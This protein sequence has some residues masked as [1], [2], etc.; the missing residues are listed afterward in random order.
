MPE[1]SEEERSLLLD[2]A[3]LNVFNFPAR[4]I[5][6]DFLSDSGTTTMTL[7][8]WSKLML[9]DESYGSN[10]GYCKLMDRIQNTFGE[11][12][13]NGE[14]VEI[15]ESTFMF[16]DSSKI[17]AFLFHQGRSAEHAIFTALGR[18]GTDMVI[19]SNGHF[20]TTEAN[21]QNNNIKALNLF[22]PE[23]RDKE[24]E[25]HFKGNID[26]DRLHKTLEKNSENIP[27]VYMTIT[28][29]TGGG[30][31]V[32]MENIKDASKLCHKYGIPFFIDACRFAENAWFIKENEDCYAD[33]NIEDIVKEIFSYADAFSISFKKDGLSNMGGGL[34]FDKNGLFVQKNPDVLDELTNHQILTEGHPTYGGMSGRDIMALEEGLKTV[35]QQGYL[36]SRINQVQ[37][38]GERMREEGLPVVTPIGGHAVYLDMNEFFADTDL[39]KEDYGGIAFTA[40]LLE[41]YGI[42]AC[43]L[44]DFAFGSVDEN[45][46]E[47]FPENNFVRFA[48]PRNRLEEQDLE[49]VTACVKSLY[50][51]RHS[52]PAVRATFGK[53]ATLRHFKARFEYAK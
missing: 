52:I 36:D 40:L 42:R 23:L 49:Y 16:P 24:S 27:A 25:F 29:N 18:T 6:V 26:I 11:Q 7:E 37:K 9:G 34:F 48:V 43:E 22:S 30:Q 38:F 8:Q 50:E 4:A 13:F 2:K 3:G 45:G 51:N 28:N 53:N 35:T 15:G 21:I 1:F 10:D 17:T 32:S 41:K 31:P 19:P 14:K 12:F 44:G 39:K 20:D 47:H 33:K 5:K 46:D